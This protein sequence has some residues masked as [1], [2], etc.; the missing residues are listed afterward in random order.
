MLFNILT[1]FTTVVASNAQ[2]LPRVDSA[3][4][5]QEFALDAYPAGSW[6][7]HTL[8]HSA[9]LAAA[10]GAHRTLSRVLRDVA[11]RESDAYHLAYGLASLMNR[12]NDGEFELDDASPRAE[13][14]SIDLPAI[15]PHGMYPMS[16]FQEAYTALVNDGRP[17]NTSRLSPVLEAKSDTAQTPAHSRGG[18]AR[19]DMVYP[20]RTLVARCAC[21]VHS[22][23]LAT[24]SV[25]ALPDRRLT[26]QALGRWASAVQWRNFVAA[27]ETVPAPAK[28]DPQV[29][30]GAV[31]DS[32]V[33]STDTSLDQACS[34]P[35]STSTI[36]EDGHKQQRFEHLLDAWAR[37]LAASGITV[38]NLAG[39]VPT[40]DLAPPKPHLMALAL[41]GGTHTVDFAACYPH[42]D[43]LASTARALLAEDECSAASNALA[44]ALGFAAS[45]AQSGGGPFSLAVV[46]TK[47]ARVVAV[48]PDVLAVELIP[49]DEA[50]RDD[51][52]D[53]M[54][55]SSTGSDLTDDH[56]EDDDDDD[57]SVAPPLPLPQVLD[58]H[59]LLSSRTLFARLPHDLFYTD[60]ADGAAYDPASLLTDECG[61]AA[62]EPPCMLGSDCPRAA[63]QTADLH[64]PAVQRVYDLFRAAI[65]ALGST[66][67]TAHLPPPQFPAGPT[68]D[69]VLAV[70]GASRRAEAEKAD[71]RRGRALTMDKFRRWLAGVRESP[72]ATRGAVPRA[73]EAAGVLVLGVHPAAMDALLQGR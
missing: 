67:R 42:V 2:H 6:G 20:D 21:G 11:V 3:P 19:L 40:D 66:S 60:P 5:S 53:S 51:E 18:P 45:C 49:D 26:R 70:A 1:G 56:D 58:V 37:V 63:A 38:T 39:N 57:S 23:P 7:A 72:P 27:L 24:L 8:E 43:E 4:L 71:L 47:L 54:V 69:T 16:P 33:K 17:G 65:L 61:P 50:E 14:L 73:L 48:S 9:A 55:Q 28:H 31:I 32:H 10:P 15:T 12:W 59:A 62:T 44:R 52:V 41:A 68:A 34:A 22:A 30:N 36:E 46:G 29:P 35:T 13:L 64:L 25:A